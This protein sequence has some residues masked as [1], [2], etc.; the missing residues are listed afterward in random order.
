MIGHSGYVGSLCIGAQFA[1]YS[2]IPAVRNLQGS[3]GMDRS[4]A[5]CGPLL[6]YEMAG[7]VKI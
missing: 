1:L 7:E 3:H 5:A 6:V 2:F 4:G